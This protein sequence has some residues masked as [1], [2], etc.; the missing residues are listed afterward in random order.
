MVA[1]GF[2]AAVGDVNWLL[3]AAIACIYAILVFGIWNTATRRYSKA[4]SNEGRS[5]RPFM[6]PALSVAYWSFFVL[7]LGLVMAWGA[8]SQLT[9]KGG[10]VFSFLLLTIGVVLIGF[11]AVVI[12]NVW[13]HRSK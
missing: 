13:R 11:A 2:L 10:S 5:E 9:S 6:Q 3:P 7:L 8:V 1:A 4:P 12:A